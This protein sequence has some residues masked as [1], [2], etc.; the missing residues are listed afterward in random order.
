[1]GNFIKNL[2]DGGLAE[3]IRAFMERVLCEDIDK[4]KIANLKFEEYLEDCAEVGAKIKSI[5]ED[6]HERFLNKACEYLESTLE[7]VLGYYGAAEFAD[8]FRKSMEE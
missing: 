2:S 4:D 3:D 6:E 7:S 8:T 1:M 5:R